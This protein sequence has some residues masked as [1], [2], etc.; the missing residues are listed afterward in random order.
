MAQ[1][2]DRVFVLKSVD[3]KEADRI[4]TVFGRERG[5]FAIIA[6]GIRKLKSSNRGN[7]QTMFLSDISYFEGTNLGVLKEAELLLVPDFR[8]EYESMQKTLRFLY[9][10]LPEDEPEPEIFKMLE[11]FLGKISVTEMN[12]FRYKG[13]QALGYI[14]SHLFCTICSER[15]K[16]KFMNMNDMSMICDS[17][18]R[19]SSGTIKETFRDTAEFGGSNSEITL[20]LDRF[21]EAL[22]E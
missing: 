19:S 18:Y 14:P 22:I 13:L 11:N 3:F 15:K 4:M 1:R 10:L 16:S 6:K 21:V 5:K 7:L 17:C 12:R 20:A 2:R 8:N 9:K